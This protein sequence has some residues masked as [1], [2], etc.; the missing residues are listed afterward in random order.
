[1]ILIIGPA[2]AVR[3]TRQPIY[4]DRDR[5][6]SSNSHTHSSEG[7]RSWLATAGITVLGI[8]LGAFLGPG[9]KK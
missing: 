7:G 9:G 8:G 4:L 6:L 3:R 5:E 1:M 2:P